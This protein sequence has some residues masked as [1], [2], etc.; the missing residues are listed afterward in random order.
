MTLLV[1]LAL[2]SRVKLNFLLHVIRYNPN[3]TQ[4]AESY[5]YGYYYYYY[6]YYYFYSCIATV[7]IAT[8]IAMLLGGLLA[9]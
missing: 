4:R 2:S 7:S 8:I 5:C 6:Y 3:P 9:R 1:E